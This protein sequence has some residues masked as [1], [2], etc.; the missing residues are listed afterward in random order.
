M[1]FTVVKIG[2]AVGA[3]FVLYQLGAAAVRNFAHAEAP[4]DEP[5]VT[6]LED[7]DFRYRCIVCGAHAVVY[8]APDGEVPEAPRHCREPMAFVPPVQ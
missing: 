7:V 3:A 2:L 6:R 1:L 5:D 4:P 8:A